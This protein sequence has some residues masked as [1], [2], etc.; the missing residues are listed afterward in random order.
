[1]GSA[2]QI[3]QLVW[4]PL[5]GAGFGHQLLGQNVERRLRRVNCVE[6]PGPDGTEQGG[7]LDQLVAGQR[8]EPTSGRAVAGVVGSAHSLEE[9]GDR[10]GGAD[11]THQLDRPDIDAE[12]QRSGGH[13]RLQVACPKPTLH[14]M[15]TILAEAAVVGGHNVV[16]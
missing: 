8:V 4:L 11:L 2:D 5:L 7:A 6:P 13:Q 16:A 15:A 14:P 3:E 9:G 1:M 12:L 10:P